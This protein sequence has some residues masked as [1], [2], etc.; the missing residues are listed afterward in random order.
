M[1]NEVRTWLFDISKAISEIDSFFDS[2]PK[3][4]AGY[5]NDLRTRRAVR[6]I[7]KLLER[8]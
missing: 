6:E 4:F 1:D 2:T 5:Q 3:T 7:L 8:H